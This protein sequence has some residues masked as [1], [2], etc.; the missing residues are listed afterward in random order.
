MPPLNA[1]DVT[2]LQL[3]PAVLC[4]ECELISYNNTDHCLAC[5]S[6]ALL[7]LSRVLGGTLRNGSTAKLVSDEIL[8]RVVDQVLGGFEIVPGEAC[9]DALCRQEQAMRAIVEEACARTEADG[10]ALALWRN[11]RIVCA[12]QLGIAPPVGAEVSPDYGISGL[13]LRTA[14]TLRCANA[15][16]D[17]LVDWQA[18]RQLGAQSIIVAPLAHLNNTVGLLQVLSSQVGAFDDMHVATVQL[19]ANLA[20]MALLQS[21][22]RRRRLESPCGNAMA[23]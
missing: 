21:S 7:S 6:T 3:Q 8:N 23:V 19:L 9:Q 17:A 18:C 5:G 14:Q 1:R 4:I 22:G 11:N 12:A 2:F 16:H 10:A 13:C 20:V 15:A